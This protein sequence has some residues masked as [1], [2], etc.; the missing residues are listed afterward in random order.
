MKWG[1]QSQANQPHVHQYTGGDRG[2]KQNEAPHINKDSSPLSVFMLYFA[3]V[4]DLLVTE[5][6]R[7]YHQYLD[8]Q[9][10][11]PIPLPDITNS[12]IFL[13]LAITVQMGHDIRDRLRDYWTRTEQ[14]FTSFY[15]SRM[16]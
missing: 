7:C 15:P 11:T 1:L 10:K 14:F 5:T 2:K 16:T 12:E 6:N 9:D 4:I 3:P 8:R 13:F